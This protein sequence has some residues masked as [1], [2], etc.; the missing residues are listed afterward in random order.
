VCGQAERFEEI[1]AEDGARVSGGQAF[2]SLHV[3]KVYAAAVDV[4]AR[5]QAASWRVHA[6]HFV[7]DDSQRSRLHAL[8]RRAK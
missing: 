6:P 5:N 2:G 7:S 4:L 1:V 8:R 3:G